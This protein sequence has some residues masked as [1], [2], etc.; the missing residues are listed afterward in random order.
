MNK[1]VKKS[2]T[3]LIL[4][5]LSL[6]FINN[7]SFGYNQ[8]IFPFSKYNSIKLLSYSRMAD[9]SFIWNFDGSIDS[10]INSNYKIQPLKIN[11]LEITCGFLGTNI[12]INNNS[13]E[14]GV[15]KHYQ[16]KILQIQKS[17]C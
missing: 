10:I 15:F 3:I 9:K 16:I 8:T 1:Y 12:S 11:N 5:I 2:I 14:F 17:Y 4:A 6:A 7:F 13:F